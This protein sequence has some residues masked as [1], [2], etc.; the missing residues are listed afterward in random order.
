MKAAPMALTLT[1]LTTPEGFERLVLAEAPEAGL[2]ALICLH[3]T[4]LGPAAGG[5]RMW[6]YADDAAAIQDVTRLARGMTHKN[7]MADLGLGGGKAVIIGDAATDKTPRMM[8]AF[9][10]AVEALEGRYWTAE[11]VGISPEDMAHAAEA[12]RFAVGLSGASGDPSPWTAEGVFRCLQTGAGHVF[13]T[14]DLTGR[15]VLVQ[16]LGHVGLSLAEKLAKA[17]ARLTLTDINSTAL[18]AA[19]RRLG[20]AVCAPDAVFDQPVEIFAPCALGGVLTDQ[21]AQDLSA[22]LICGA[23]NNQ[24]AHDG[25]AGA[26]AARGITYLPD[27]VVN[28]GGIIS[29]ASE[30]HGKPDTWRLERL[31]AIA[32][33]VGDMLARAAQTGRAPAEVADEMVAA[34]LSPRRAA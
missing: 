33:R 13:G 29:V 16:G 28:A 7:A 14:A 3:S 30:I 17:G 9:G 5:C 20:A 27:Y 11:D 2:R 24:L 23:A 10:E 31:T 25:V 8:R 1:D 18:Q 22:S 26:L 21:T 19:A 4:A 15:R 32:G 12:T 34:M 6:S